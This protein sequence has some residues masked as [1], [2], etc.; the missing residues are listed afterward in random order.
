MKRNYTPISRLLSASVMLLLVSAITL[1]GQAPSTINYH[2]L[3]RDTEGIPRA[4]VSVSLEL[5]IHQGTV[6]GAV[7][8]SE[9]HNTTTNDFGLVNL[10]IGSVSPAN[11][12]L[13]DWSAGPYFVE[14]SVDGTSMGASELLTVP[15]ALHAGFAESV[16]ISGSEAA[17]AGWDKN[18]ADD[19]DG[20]FGSLTGIPGDIADGDDDTHL[21][22]GQVEAYIDG[23]E[24]SFN[25]WDKNAADDFD[26]AFGS[27]SGTP[28]TLSGYG[29]TN[30][31]RIT[32]LNSTC[33]SLA[34]VGTNYARLTNIGT[35]T[36]ENSSSFIEATFNGRIAVLGTFGGSGVIFELRIDG[37]ATT[38]GR[39]R[40][41][42]KAS[43]GGTS[44]I[45]VTMTGI[46]PGLSSGT[47]TVSMWV[48]SA[49]GTS[50]QLYLDPGCW[51][52]DVVI[53]REYR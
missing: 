19:F 5:D 4:N 51:S 38:S 31:E 2:A 32:I 44:G 41:N 33:L 20:A 39:A 12:A 45:H 10:E 22:E 49:Q 46:F 14:V 1:I 26:G 17:F 25:G 36:K 11:F 27:L 43:E 53:V 35:F 30:V 37:V 16:E 24:T 40:A 13:I 34:S 7:V 18:E 21:S 8:Y 47:H 9:T 3:L 48:R 42:V 50:T 28:N 15:Y 6:T 29:V 23:D 52:S